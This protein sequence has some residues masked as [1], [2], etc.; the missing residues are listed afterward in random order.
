MIG[1]PHF[2]I[3]SAILFTVGL[4]IVVTRRHGIMMLM[5]LEIILNACN[6]NLVAFSR[7]VEGG[8]RGQAFALFVVIIAAAE[9][10]IALAIILSIYSNLA[11]INLDDLRTLKE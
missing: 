1:L 5:G 3:V 10:A 6:L 9:A 8:V 2:L 7:Y 11:K 4:F